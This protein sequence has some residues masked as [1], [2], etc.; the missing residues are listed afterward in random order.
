MGVLALNGRSTATLMQRARDGKLIA[1]VADRDL[2]KN[3]VEVNFF[4]YPAKMPAG[5][6]LLAIRTGVPLITAFVSYQAGGINIELKGIEIPQEGTDAE[7]V[8][9]VVQR[10]ADHF[11]QGIERHP[12]D[13]HMLQRIWVDGDFKERI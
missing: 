10:C 6:A 5:P 13:W 7:K 12:E 8:S 2:S 11:A 4:G 1:L 9:I 3:G